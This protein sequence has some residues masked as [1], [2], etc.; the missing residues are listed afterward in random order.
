ME[1]QVVDRAKLLIPPLVISA[2]QQEAYVAADEDG[3]AAMMATLQADEQARIAAIKA[4][5]L[6]LVVVEV[7][8]VEAP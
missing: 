4:G 3:R 7:P 5:E 2:E 6:P 1:Y 8:P